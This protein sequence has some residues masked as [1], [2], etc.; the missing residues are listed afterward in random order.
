MSNV[1][2]LL[3]ILVVSG[4]VVSAI[5][6][7]NMEK[8]LSSVIALGVTGIFCAAAFLV[9]HA[10]DVAISEVA[11]GAALTPLVLIVALK[12]MRGRDD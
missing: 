8:L 9:M 10:P 4:V 3:D 7:C 11:V 6:A 5:L 2:A 12:K 1:V